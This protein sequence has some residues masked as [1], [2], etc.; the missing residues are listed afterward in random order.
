MTLYYFLRWSILLGTGLLIYG[1]AFQFDF[2]FD[3][4]T[5]ITH[6]FY[7][8]DFSHIPWMW[9]FFPMTRLVGTYSFALNYYFNQ[10]H[11][12][13]YH[14][15]NFIV[16]L[17]SVGLVWALAGLLFKITKISEDRLTKELPFMIAVLFLV[18]PGQT[19][20]VTYIAQRFESMATVFYLGTMYCYLCARLSKRGRH[21]VILFGLSGL[22]TILGIMTKETVITVP[23][24]MLASEWI[25]FPRKDYTR[26]YIVLAVGGVLLYMLFTRLVHS[27]LSIFSRSIPSESHGGD[28]LTPVGYFLTQMRV[29]LTFLRLLALPVHQNLDYDYPASSGLLHPPLT[30]VGLSV[31]CGI[32]FL[33]IKLRRKVPLIAFGL[34][35]MLITFSINLVPRANV[36][37][38][39]KL[40][41]ISFGYFLAL[42]AALS[43]LVRNRG[44][45]VWILL[46]M[47]TVLGVVSFQ[48]NK[49]W[50]NE[51]TLWDDTV[52]ESPNKA[53]PYNNR[54]GAYSNQGNLTGALSDYN[55]AIE[56]NPDY[57]RNKLANI[58]INRAITG[59]KQG[60][61]AQA[62]SDFTKAY[63]YQQKTNDER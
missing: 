44:A 53:R 37:F 34:A 30:L 5:F 42:V 4:I 58:Y 31:I 21:K 48:R 7:I 13:G 38:E 17:V 35:W 36:I 27:D 52:R 50:R 24:M 16:H 28:V 8:R 41:L 54:G 45:L 6:N 12:Q 22:L 25:L 57:D 9:H 20:A 2:V 43:I 56:I 60:N 40:Y 61:T 1:Q 39:H 62:M 15:F 49:V 32:I 14:I 26:F 10:L 55:R 23:L 33:I 3:D 19:Q 46:G 63:Q 59:I 29:F 51:F 11:P 18:H 47:V